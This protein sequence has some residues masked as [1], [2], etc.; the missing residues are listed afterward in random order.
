M[1]AHNLADT[2]GASKGNGSWQ[3]NPGATADAVPSDRGSA[4]L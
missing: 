4:L 2:I 1:L 3:N